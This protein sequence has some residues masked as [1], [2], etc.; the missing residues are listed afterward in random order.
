MEKPFYKGLK[1]GVLGGGQLGRMLLQKSYSYNLEM[2]FIDPDA[3]APC[4]EIS[5][6]FYRGDLNNFKLVYD[7]GKK[8]DVVTIEIE[9]VN[10][11][12]LEKLEQEGIKVFPQPR[13][14]KIVQDKGLQKLFYKEYSFPSSDFYLIENKKD[15][16]LFKDQL[17]IVQKLR[18]GGYDGKGV[19]ILKNV[20]DFEK[21]FDGPCIL[22]KLV[23]I[24]QEIS[25]IACRGQNGDVKAF[26]PVE[27]EFNPEANLVEF[28]FSPASISSEM[29]KAA[30]ELA[31][32][33][34]T[35]LDM[36]GILAVEM[37]L[38]KDNEL[39]VNEIAPRPHNSGH[40]TI[41][42]N[43]TSQYDQLLRC[44]I[45]MP[46]G[47]TDI[48]IPSVMVNLLGEKDFMGYAK[49]KDIEKAMAIDGVNIHIYGKA[50]TKSFRKMGHVTVVD[51]NIEKAKEK[52][53]IVKDT[54]KVIA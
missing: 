7:F 9:N 18:K 44:L 5:N 31:K 25:V 3:N 16:E 48:T 50:E 29:E 47:N 19:Q 17:P 10:V 34:I 2:A 11:E 26:P 45:G 42:G 37:F 15:L 54:L 36:V 32:N 33:I 28:L 39:L 14:I 20:S 35:K 53:K 51:K 23:D 43:V 22:E 21:A 4:R 38:T 40:Q 12:A 46:L 13:C 6:W 41:E 30:M 24:K 8:C 1:I 27:M 52:A 49:Y